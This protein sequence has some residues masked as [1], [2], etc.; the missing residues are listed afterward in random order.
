M[1]PSIL[2]DALYTGALWMLERERPLDAAHFFR[3]MLLQTPTDERA[4]LGLGNCHEQIGQDEEAKELYVT[5]TVAAT[6]RVKCMIALS[7]LFRRNNDEDA[8]DRILE[9]AADLAPL[10]DLE[11]LVLFERGNP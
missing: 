6:R 5:G 4:W 8:A 2:P 11:E 7:R 9:E 1:N 10:E 3:A